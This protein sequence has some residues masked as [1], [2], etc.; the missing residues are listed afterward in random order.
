[1]IHIPTQNSSAEYKRNE[2]IE[3]ILIP[4]IRK[5]PNNSSNTEVENS[6]LSNAYQ[7]QSTANYQ[8]LVTD[9]RVLRNSPTQGVSSLH[10]KKQFDLLLLVSLYF[11]LHF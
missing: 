2:S 8:T 6:T 1:M 4:K 9:A 7:H 3:E 10:Y 5:I 11:V